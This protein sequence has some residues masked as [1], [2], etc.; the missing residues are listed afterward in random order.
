MGKVLERSLYDEDYFAWT[1]QQAA[2]LRRL[3]AARVDSTLDVLSLAEE[4]ESLG[5]SDLNSVRSQL[6]RIIG[7]C[8]SSSCRRPP[9]RA[10]I[11]ATRSP[12]RAT[13]SRTT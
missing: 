5:Q 10:R 4:V 8:S 2:E 9:R 12:L 3:A 7:I 6:R 13:R 1:R 11:G